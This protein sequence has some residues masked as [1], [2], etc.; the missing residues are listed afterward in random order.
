MT[1]LSFTNLLSIDTSTR[2]LRL[3]LS[4]GEDRV[5]NVG[6]E[7][8]QAHGQM[9]MKKIAD[10]FASAQRTP[11]DLHG[12]VV[13]TG[14]GSF[15]GLRIGIA[16]AKGMVQALGIPIVGVSVFEAAAY[17]LRDEEN[18]VE[19]VTAVRRDEFIVGTVQQGAFE[20]SSVR[21]ASIT[22]LAGQLQNRPFA[23]VGL[24]EEMRSYSSGGSN[25]SHRI[26]FDA[27][28]I[29]QIG[30]TKLE[31]GQASD[32]ATLEPLYIQKSQAEIRFEQRQP[33]QT[34]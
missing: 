30:K 24:S 29:L 7:A 4:F 16:S 12:I 17:M 34:N 31:N 11:R 19:I 1:D 21:V 26:L 5:I 32:V 10:L 27:S 8:D 15:T 33:K 23:F 6:E 22:E 9:I 13:C 25:L 28:H 3:A 14:P 20:M 2:Y 18:P